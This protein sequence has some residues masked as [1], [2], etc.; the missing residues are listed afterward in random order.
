[1]RTALKKAREAPQSTKAR[2]LATA[3]RVF[4]ARGFAGASTREIVRRYV[5]RLVPTLLGMKPRKG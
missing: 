3:Q 4:A 2:I 5:M 1:M